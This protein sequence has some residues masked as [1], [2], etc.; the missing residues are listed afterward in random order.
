MGRQV[1]V[2]FE[3]TLLPGRSI[4]KI[5]V[6]SLSPGAYLLSLEQDGAP[7]RSQMILVTP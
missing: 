3:G 7:S 2:L 1:A 4:V 6:T 5:D